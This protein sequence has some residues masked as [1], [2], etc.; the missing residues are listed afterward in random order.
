MARKS[1]GISLYRDKRTGNWGVRFRHQGTRHA[2]S[3]GTADLGEAKRIAARKYEEF[4]SAKPK[5]IGKKDLDVLV[6]EWLRSI[7]PPTVSQGTWDADCFR[8]KK[9]LLPHFKTVQ[10][11]TTREVEV[12]TSKRLQ[13]VR[14]STLKKELGTLRRFVKWAYLHQEI[15]D[16]IE[17]PTPSRRV[18]GNQAQ[19]RVRVDL[20][21][22][23]AEAILKALPERSKM[24]HPVK[25]LFTLIWETGL[26]I[27]GVR[28]LKAPTHWKPGQ[29]FLNIT[30]DIDKS[31]YGRL[32]DL[33][34]RCQRALE[35][36]YESPGLLFGPY[37]YMKTLRSAAKKA[38]LSKEECK[39][40]D[41]RDFRHAA[42]TDF[43]ATTKDIAS[44]SYIAGH[45]Q[46]STTSKYVHPPREG[47]RKAMSTRFRDPARDPEICVE[48]NGSAFLNDLQ[49]T[50]R[51]S[52][53]RLL[54]PESRNQGSKTKLTE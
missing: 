41:A 2:R 43:A 25:A 36:V 33:S 18:I 5:P 21:P 35:D 8:W 54:P 28:R 24:G 34:P 37:A 27:E 19:E 52:N 46:L 32:L 53:P 11:L 49:R 3:T 48:L 38:G 17:V 30:D 12:Y 4:L 31:R 10:K 13:H 42:L 29:D 26:R 40:L 1:E 50:R 16:L 47:A 23:Q 39:Y 9:H 51:D 14:R 6:A 44:V 22:K 15:P 20:T 45:K 7:E